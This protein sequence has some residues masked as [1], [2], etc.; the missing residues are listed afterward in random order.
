MGTVKKRRN[1][2]REKETKKGTTSASSATTES[3]K[4]S[5][6]R[7]FTE[8]DIDLSETTW[9]VIRRHPLFW[10][11]L[12][13][14]VPYML[15][16]GWRWIV[17]QHPFLPGM[18]PAVGMND[19]RQVLII[20]T[21][22]SGTSSMAKGLR[23][24]VGIEV[25]HEDSDTL[26][27]FVRD[28]TVSWFHGIRY[29]RHP[30]NKSDSHTISDLCRVAWRLRF[31]NSNYGFGPTLFGTP[32]YNC[33]VVHPKFKGCFHHACVT[34]LTREYGCALASNPIN[35][36]G[37][38]PPFQTTLLQ[39][40]E[41]WKIVQS[42]VAKYCLEDD[43]IAAKP[44]KT[45][46]LLLQAMGLVINEDCV[47]QMI[48]YVTGFY[49]TILD[50]YPDIVVYPV[51]RTTPCQ[52]AILAGLGNISTTVYSPN[53]DLVR[54]VCQREETDEGPIETPRKNLINRGRISLQDVL[55]HTTPEVVNDLKALYQRLGYQYPE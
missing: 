40:R 51:E 19:P 1:A 21:M 14:G 18:R 53:H 28:G 8:N 2:T 44:P 33:S 38:H 34:A 35:G 13:L 50:H 24:D 26:W 30:H 48:L 39:T 9:A 25:G 12:L 23:E 7:E 36:G 5:I 42:L 11:L 31:S 16:L 20:G 4:P 17:L 54:D 37:C 41:P 27:T 22:S 6:A 29:W 43:K 10:G 3:T 32:E 55:P 52:V 47:E 49:N 45:L 46:W 15:Y